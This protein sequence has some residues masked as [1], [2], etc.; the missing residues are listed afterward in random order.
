AQNKLK[1]WL[2]YSAEGAESWSS[3]RARVA[4]SLAQCTRPCIIVAHLA[5]NSVIR[6]LLTGEPELEFQQG[7]CEIVKLES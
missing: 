2:G 4:S 6:Q 5:V 1:D 3:F 7:Y